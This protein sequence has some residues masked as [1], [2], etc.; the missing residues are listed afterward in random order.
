MPCSSWWYCHFKH[1]DRA[2]LHKMT[3]IYFQICSRPH[4]ESGSNCCIYS[5]ILC[6]CILRVLY[7]HLFTV[8]IKM[9]SPNGYLSATQRPLLIVSIQMSRLIIFRNI[10]RCSGISPKTYCYCSFFL[11][12]RQP[13]EHLF[14]IVLFF[15]SSS[16]SSSHWTLSAENPILAK[17]TGTWN[18]THT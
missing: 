3:W 11:G 17:L 10:I 12:V 9:K 1:C 2:F 18:L 14:E 4:C 5:A 8:T 13:P 6:L 15:F 16:S 7:L